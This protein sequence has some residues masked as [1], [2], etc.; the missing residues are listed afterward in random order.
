MANRLELSDAEWTTIYT[1]LVAHPRVRVGDPE[2]CRRFLTA[3]LWVLRVG[4]QW[5]VLPEALG[6]WNSV[7]KRFSRWCAQG[8]WEAIHK[9]CIHLPD[10]QTVFID[11]TIVRAHPCAA[12]AAHS[13]AQ[14]EALG[15]SR[16]GFTTKAHALTDALGYPLDSVLSGGQESDIGQAETLL[17][18]TPQGAEALGADKAYDSDRF[19]ATIKERGMEAVIPPR[20]NRTKPRECDWFTYAE[21]HVIECF[22]NKIKHYR[23][24]FSRFEKMARNYKGFFHFVSALIWLR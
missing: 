4:G 7:F 21:R 1:T 2:Q 3:V 22:F 11:S 10:L 8:V 5:R 20:T 23:R 19:L 12:G 16:G 9:G 6:H 13:R 15:R 24:I 18:L 14:E 17:A